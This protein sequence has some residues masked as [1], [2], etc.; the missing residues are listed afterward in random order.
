MQ[1][2]VSISAGY[3]LGCGLRASGKAECW[4]YNAQNQT[5]VPEETW[6]QISAAGDHACGITSDGRLVCWG[7]DIYG[8]I[9]GQPDADS[10]M[11]VAVAAKG[12]RTCGILGNGTLI[13]WG[14]TSLADNSNEWQAVSMIS[15]ASTCAII[16]PKGARSCA[17]RARVL[18]S[19]AYACLGLFAGLSHAALSCISNSCS[20]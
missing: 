9:S 13:C 15:N 19:C 18:P 17:A 12:Y 20:S 16:A 6:G 4:G 3:H 8:A 2:W 5:V 10:E 1:D 7:L 14:Q 11:W